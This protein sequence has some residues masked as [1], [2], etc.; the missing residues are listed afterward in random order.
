MQD[1]NFKNLPKQIIWLIT[2]KCNYECSYCINKERRRDLCLEVENAD[3][4]LRNIEKKLGKNWEFLISGGEPFLHKNF[5]EIVKGLVKLGHWVTVV[6]NFSINPREII[7]FLELVGDKCG[8][9]R[10]S[11][12]LEYTNPDEFL[13]KI[14][15]IEKSFP[16]LRNHL[17]ITSL[18][19][20]ENL[21]RLEKIKKKFFEKGYQ[22]YTQL[23][24]LPYPD[25]TFFPYSGKQKKIIERI[26]KKYNLKQF[27]KQAE[28]YG[29]SGADFSKVRFKGQKCWAGCLYFS[30]LPNGAAFRCFPSI[31]GKFEGGNAGYLGNILRKDFKLLKGATKCQYELCNFSNYH[32]KKLR[33]LDR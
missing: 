13:K 23:V 9:I 8:S 16:A 12:R 7:R 15:I 4:F 21:P 29:T 10:A 19:T 30:M 14:L 1:T 11:L 18:V 26:S 22:F 5:F 24:Q 33:I 32:L 3:L 27:Q 20:S 2:S 6:T 17:F 25:Q 28:F 31:E